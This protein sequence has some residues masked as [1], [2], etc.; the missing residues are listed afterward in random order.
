MSKDF[1]KLND[2]WRKIGEEKPYWGVLTNDLFLPE[3]IDDNIEMFYEKGRADVR[4][5]RKIARAIDFFFE[6][7]VF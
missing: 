3:N 1:E 2:D 4:K 6:G 5:L 7:N